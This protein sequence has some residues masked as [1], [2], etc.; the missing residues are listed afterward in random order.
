MASGGTDTLLKRSM[1]AGS[2]RLPSPPEPSLSRWSMSMTK[3]TKCHRCNGSAT[4]VDKAPP[5][6][7]GDVI[8]CDREKTCVAQDEAA[9]LLSEAKD[10]VS[11][12]AA[13]A[14]DEGFSSDARLYL[15]EAVEDWRKAGDAF[16]AAVAAHGRA[17]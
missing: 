15:R 5:G 17:V 14:V 3:Q 2:I 11:N 8:R 13:E 12:A 10:A 6:E 4:M 9:R 1:R 16:L 7:S